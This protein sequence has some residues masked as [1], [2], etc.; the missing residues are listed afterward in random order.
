MLQKNLA[1]L[2]QRAGRAAFG[3]RRV[4][5]T[6]EGD[7]RAVGWVKTAG[8]ITQTVHRGLDEARVQLART[9]AA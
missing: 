6:P 4:S 1:F 9:M 5:A 2:D 3:L 7:R 8:G